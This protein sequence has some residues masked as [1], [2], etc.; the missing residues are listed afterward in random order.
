MN[1]YDSNILIVDDE[2]ALREMVQE[3]LEKEGYLHIDTAKDCR[4]A[5][6]LFGNKEY[7]MVLLDIMLP[8]GDGFSLYEELKRAMSLR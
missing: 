5:R 8:D 3:L 1:L 4:Q 2:P 6:E 7:H